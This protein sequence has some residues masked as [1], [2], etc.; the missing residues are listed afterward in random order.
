[1][2]S[3]TNLHLAC[4]TKFKTVM[5]KPPK[6]KIN[7]YIPLI[8]LAGENEKGIPLPLLEKFHWFP[9]GPGSVQLGSSSSMGTTPGY[10]L[11]RK[12]PHKSTVYQKME[13][14]K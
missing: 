2:V 6:D 1:M 5:N 7:I 9:E 11:E 3:S 12:L 14:G 8:I 10:Y 13:G 4:H